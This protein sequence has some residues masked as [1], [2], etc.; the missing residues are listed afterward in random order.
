MAP[1]TATAEA[2]ALGYQEALIAD[3]EPG[4]NPRTHF[5]AT[6]DAELAAN[7][8]VNGVL[9]PII[10]RPHPTKTSKLQLVAGERRFRAARTSG[11]ERI[12]AIVRELSD[13][14]ALEIAI[15]ENVQRHALDPLDEAKGY[16]ALIESNRSKYSPAYIA[17]RIGRSEKFVWDRMKLL[18]LIPELKELLDEERIL[19]G[20]AELLARLKPEDQE[21]AIDPQRGANGP[22]RERSGLWRHEAT[23]ALASEEGETLVESL[24]KDVYQGL[25]PVTVKE[26]EAWVARHVR[27]D[28]EHMAK[29]APLDFGE[30][31]ERVAAAVAQPGR[32]R[33]MVWITEDFRVDDDAKDPRERT[34]GSQSWRRADGEESPDCEHSVLGVFAA[35]RGYGTSLQVCVARDRCKVHFAKEIRE[36]ARSAKQRAQGGNQTADAD[37][38]NAKARADAEEQR[39][40]AAFEGFKALYPHVVAAVVAALPRTMDR[41]VF[42]LIY[43]R[44]AP[45]VQPRQFVE[46]L[47]RQKLE[48]FEPSSAWSADWQRK[49]LE[50]LAKYFRVDVKKVE[51]QVTAQAKAASKN[52]AK[53][54]K[55][56]KRTKPA[57]KAKR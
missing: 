5:N 35:G 44:E 26:L 14:Q 8:L 21:R 42:E 24:G 53:A 46:L 51:S 27:F 38:E 57:K 48:G 12:P 45:D 1:A 34:Y 17:D 28:V 9:E 11:L 25:K 18:D 31:A 20:H 30:T 40:Q 15:V 47:V 36:R 19:V 55:A 29:A 4:V 2:M 33:K 6:A 13:E 37:R 52:G 23:L 43:G 10:V 39:R 32:G 22:G 56:E 16:R 54:A 3:I 41:R 49:G 7:V 50:K